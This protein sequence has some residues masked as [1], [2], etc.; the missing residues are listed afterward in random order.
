M[1]PLQYYL[2][3]PAAKDNSITHA[4]GAPSNLDAATTM[5]SAETELQNTIELFA[6]VSEIAA[7]KPDL[8]AKVEK[9]KFEAHF[10]RILKRTITSAKIAKICWQITLAAWMQPLQNDLRSSAAKDNRI[11][12]AAAAPSNLDAAIAIRF[13]A[14]RRKPAR[15]YTHTNTRW[16]QACSH[17]NAIC[18]Q[19]FQNTQELRTHKHTRSSLKPPLQC[20]KK[21][22]NRPQ[23]QPPHTG[24]TLSAAATLHGKT[25]GFVL[26]LPPQHKPHATV[27]QPLQCVSQHHVANLHVSTHMATP[28]DN[29]HAAIPMRSATTDSKTPCNYA[30]TSTPK[31]LYVALGRRRSKLRRGTVA[32]F[33]YIKRQDDLLIPWAFPWNQPRKCDSCW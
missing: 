17:S 19:R 14:S 29:N 20:G 7:P 22:A 33:D 3:D 4:A 15:I 27:M 13:A 6:M 1:Q 10:K 30:G 2:Q 8:D 25:Q 21:K 16:Q 11:T 9:T 31:A 24:G 23:P 18:N 26:Q 5:R 12:H 28:Y 32:Q